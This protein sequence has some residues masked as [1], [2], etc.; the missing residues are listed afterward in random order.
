MAQTIHYRTYNFSDAK[1]LLSSYGFEYED[2]TEKH[3]HFLEF[4]RV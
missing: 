4:K 3:Q 1:Q 2:R